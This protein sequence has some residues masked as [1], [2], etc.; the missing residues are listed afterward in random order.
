MDGDSCRGR[1]KYSHLVRHSHLRAPVYDGLWITCVLAPALPTRPALPVAM[2]SSRAPSDDERLSSAE[3]GLA[4]EGYGA[5]L[6]PEYGHYETACFDAAE[7]KRNLG[8]DPGQHCWVEI[9]SDKHQHLYDLT[10]KHVGKHCRISGV[11][12]AGS[13][14]PTIK[15]W[16]EDLDDDSARRLALPFLSNLYPG[17]SAGALPAPG[18]QAKVVTLSAGLG[19]SEVDFFSKSGEACV[20]KCLNARRGPVVGTNYKARMW[21]TMVLF[22]EGRENSETLAHFI[23]SILNNDNEPRPNQYK[24]FRYCIDIGHWK[25]AATKTSRTIDSVVLPASTKDKI[26]QDLDAFSNKEACDFYTSHGIP[27]KRSYLFYGVPGAGKTSLLT[28]LAGKYHRNLCLLQPTDP[29]FTDHTLSEAVREAPPN[30]IMVLEDVDALFGRD[31]E[32]SNGKTPLTFS[33]LLNALDGIGNPDGQVFV[34]TTNHRDRLDPALIRNGRVDMHVEFSHATPEQ[35]EMIF[36]QFYPAEAP[37]VVVQFRKATLAV[38]GDKK[39]N[40]AALQHF[41]IRMMRKSASEAIACV[42]SIVDD[43]NEKQVEAQG[44][45]DNLYL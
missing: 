8:I 25:C 30:S 19:L 37:E 4:G 33:G 11:N 38:L 23:E 17:G 21:E 26:I 32:A 16:D 29:R 45:S 12:G 43:L 3:T 27:Y 35:M 13:F 9:A 20:I 18:K 5:Q 15:A 22:L 1:V 36:R 40:M 14:T 7:L 34:L 44:R 10:V 31:R 28:A 24:I 41:F 2:P 6:R 39:V 42:S